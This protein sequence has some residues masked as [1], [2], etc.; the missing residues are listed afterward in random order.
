MEENDCSPRCITI[1]RGLNVKYPAVNAF[2]NTEWMADKSL[3][4]AKA[5]DALAL[6]RVGSTAKSMSPHTTIRR[7]APAR[8]SGEKLRREAPA[9]SSG[10]K[11]RRA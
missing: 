8:S 7:G 3:I 10:E 5:A 4:I 6:S 2:L 9:R 11:L 1:S